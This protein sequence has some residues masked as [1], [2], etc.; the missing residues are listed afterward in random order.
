MYYQMLTPYIEHSVIHHAHLYVRISEVFGKQS[1]SSNISSEHYVKALQR[2]NL[3]WT[4][5]VHLLTQRTAK[6]PSV[7]SSQGFSSL[8]TCI[9]QLEHVIYVKKCW[10]KNEKKKWNL[11]TSVCLSCTV[12]IYTWKY[13][14]YTFRQV[15]FCPKGL[16]LWLYWDVAY[17]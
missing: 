17:H 2:F 15:D 5:K 13:S 14:T 10:V 6:W 16:R 7:Q 8:S 12:K 11:A 9:S 3:L 4:C 1:K